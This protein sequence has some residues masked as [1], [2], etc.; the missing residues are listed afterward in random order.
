MTAQRPLPLVPVTDATLMSSAAALVEDGQGGRV[1]IRGELVFAWDAGDEAGRRLAA[2]QLV[3]IKAATGV[4]V[5]AGFG[6]D[7]EMLRRWGQR[8][9]AVGIVALAPNRRGPKGPSKLTKE[10]SV[11]IVGLRGQRRSLRA[12][13]AEVGVSTDTV[14]RA[15]ADH[16]D[17]RSACGHTTDSD[18]DRAPAGASVG[19]EVDDVPGI[20]DTDRAG[21]AAV[22]RDRLPVL[23]DP[24]PRYT[25]RE[26]ARWGLLDHARPTFTPSARVPLAGLFLALPGLEA[27]GLLDCARDAFG[28]LPNGFYGLDSVLVEAA[29]R[30]LAGQ[31]RVEGATRVD[32]IALGRVLGLDRAPEVKTN[33]RACQV[34]CVSS[35]FGFS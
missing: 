29:L 17:S 16:Q 7:P 2:V 30:T 4:A 6:V 18:Q 27:T 25:E 1:F 26:L 19:D 28:R 10:L 34:F 21:D 5:A 11:R 23:A 22:D 24:V 32:P 15:L 12:I 9:D 14:R 31:P 20:E 3:R 13:A 8:A 33:P 35:A